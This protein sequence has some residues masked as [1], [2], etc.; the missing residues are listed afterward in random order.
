M[1]PR[2]WI[3]AKL[4]RVAKL[5]KQGVINDYQY[6]FLAIRYGSELLR[7]PLRVGTQIDYWKF[8]RDVSELLNISKDDKDLSKLFRAY[9]PLNKVTVILKSDGERHLEALKARVVSESHPVLTWT[10]DFENGAT[11]AEL[12]QSPF[13]RWGFKVEEWWKEQE[14][15]LPAMS[16]GIVFIL[17]AIVGGIIGYLLK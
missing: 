14:R 7:R 15:L 11:Q 10:S 16:K 13:N 1:A 9:G 12:L 3:R 5:H 8:D 17:G 2:W 4:K 6:A